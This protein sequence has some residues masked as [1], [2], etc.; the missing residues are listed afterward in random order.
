M[1]HPAGLLGR[2]AG[3]V[4]SSSAEGRWSASRGRPP[5]RRG[6]AP[7]RPRAGRP[8]ARGDRPNR[9]KRP[10]GRSVHTRLRSGPGPLR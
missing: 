6:A 5:G 1:R 7:A 2:A 10:F 4:P 9:R 8:G 3:C